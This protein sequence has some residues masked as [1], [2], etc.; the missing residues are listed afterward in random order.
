MGNFRPIRVKCWENFLLSRGCIQ[1]SINASHHKWKCP[2]CMQSI[3][4]RG[5]EKEIPFAHIKT[6]LSTMGI[7]KDVFLEW[8][9]ENC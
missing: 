9:K 7:D 4:F 3:I 8:I 6:N 1:N 2:D 5:A